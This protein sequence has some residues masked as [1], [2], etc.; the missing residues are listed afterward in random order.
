LSIGIIN[1]LTLPIHHYAQ[2]AAVASEVKQRAK[3]DN[4]PNQSRYLW[5]CRMEGAPGTPS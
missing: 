5:D 4:H 3:R 1:T 2:L